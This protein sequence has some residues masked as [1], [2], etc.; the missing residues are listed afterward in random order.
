MTRRNAAI[1]ASQLSFAVAVA[2]VIC[3][4]FP[5]RVAD[6]G[7]PDPFLVRFLGAPFFHGT[8][9]TIASSG[10]SRAFVLPLAANV[11]LMSGMIF[12]ALSLLRRIWPIRPNPLDYGLL[13]LMG[14]PSVAII[15]TLVGFVW[16]NDILSFTG[17]LPSAPLANCELS[18][19]L[20]PDTRG[21]QPAE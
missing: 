19:Q 14:L 15:L 3:L 2:L 20:A 10:V 18:W 17:S 5:F 21:R 7:P 9:H 4:A 1:H 6:C 8:G 11:A 12:V 13:V 16:T